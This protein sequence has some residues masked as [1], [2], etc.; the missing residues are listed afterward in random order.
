MMT[1]HGALI[2]DHYIAASTLWRDLI[3]TSVLVTQKLLHVV[4]EEIGTLLEVHKS[5]HPF[6]VLAFLKIHIEVKA[7]QLRM[8]PQM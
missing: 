1:A 8:S 7:V 3:S 5:D 6:M 2:V 4:C